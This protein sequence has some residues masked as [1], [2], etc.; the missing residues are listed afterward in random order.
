[1]AKQPVLFV[2]HGSPMNIVWDNGYT[3]ALRHM[4]ETLPR[5]KAILVVSAHWLTDS[6]YVTSGERPQTIYD[7]YGFPP[8]LYQQSYPC[9]GSPELAGFI[10]RI[11]GGAVQCDDERG[12]DHAAWAVLTHMYPKADIPAQLPLSIRTTTGASA[13]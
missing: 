3:R 11:T 2:G 8:E 1:M 9:S 5:P 4:G 12:I 13:G 7:F 6:T 10:Q